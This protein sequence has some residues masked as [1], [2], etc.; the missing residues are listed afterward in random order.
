MDMVP[1][2]DRIPIAWCALSWPKPN[3]PPDAKSFGACVIL[4]V[5]TRRIF[6]ANYQSKSLLTIGVLSLLLLRFIFYI[7]VLIR[8]IRTMTSPFWEGTWK[9]HADGRHTR[10]SG[11]EKFQSNRQNQIP[12]N[13]TPLNNVSVQKHQTLSIR[14]I[15]QVRWS[16]VLSVNKKYLQM[17]HHFA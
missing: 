3:T 13:Q 5:V 12:T 16:V 8:T 15:E 7:K 2:C 9:P 6:P 4:P 1:R 10:S 14:A 11:L 17:L